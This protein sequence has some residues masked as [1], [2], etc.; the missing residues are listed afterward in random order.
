MSGPRGL[1]ARIRSHERALSRQGGRSMDSCQ[2]SA[3]SD[4]RRRRAAAAHRE[5]RERSR[6]APGTPR[7]AV[8]GGTAALGGGPVVRGP[9]PTRR[10]SSRER[11]PA[12]PEGVE[13][14]PAP[15]RQQQVAGRA[16][17]LHPGVVVVVVEDG[18]GVQ[19]GHA[20]AAHPQV[21]VLGRRRSRS[22]LHHPAATAARLRR[23]P[24]GS[25]V[26]STS[27]TPSAAS[28]ASIG[29]PAAMA[30]WAS[31]RCTAVSCAIRRGQKPAFFGCGAQ[32]HAGAS[33]SSAV[34][35]G[36][37]PVVPLLPELERGHARRAARRGSPAGRLARSSPEPANECTQW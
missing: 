2:E 11:S 32:F 34:E 36:H 20:L 29:S 25:Q 35:E 3:L 8:P 6:P 30:S 1:P 14:D 5:R 4:L 19:Q 18:R 31:H 7:A 37:Q 15:E 23:R 22:E 24:A 16:A 17:D 28:F 10:P 21:P 9:Q 27:L 12:T 33:G 26:S 13:A